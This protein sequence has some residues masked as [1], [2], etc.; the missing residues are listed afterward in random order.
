MA[1]NNTLENNHSV[2]ENSFLYNCNCNLLKF[3]GKGNYLQDQE[4]QKV[5]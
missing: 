4:G 5:S 2:V 1:A 3:S